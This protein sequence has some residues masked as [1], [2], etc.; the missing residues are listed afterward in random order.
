VWTRRTLRDYYRR[1]AMQYLFMAEGELKLA[2]S[3]GNIISK[4]ERLVT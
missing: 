3:Q 4:Q 1:V 2:E